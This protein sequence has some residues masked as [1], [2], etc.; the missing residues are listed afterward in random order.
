MELQVTWICEVKLNRRENASVPLLIT[1]FLQKH[2]ITLLII[3]AHFG[4]YTA[5]RYITFKYLRNAN[6]F[7]PSLNHKVINILPT[8]KYFSLW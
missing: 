1:L 4:H 7:V 8:S 5:A 3:V 6:I 2:Y